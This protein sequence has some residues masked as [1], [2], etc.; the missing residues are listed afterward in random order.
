MVF[1]LG[2]G[3]ILSSGLTCLW[4]WASG[5]SMLLFLCLICMCVYFPNFLCIADRTWILY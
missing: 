5:T 4:F 3:F 1:W 2:L